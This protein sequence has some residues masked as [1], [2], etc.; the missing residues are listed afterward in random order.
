[1][2]FSGTIQHNDF[3]VVL[4][5]GNKPPFSLVGI[6]KYRELFSVGHGCVPQISSSFAECWFV[7][8]RS[9]IRP[10]FFLVADLIF[11]H[12]KAQGS[13]SP[14]LD[15]RKWRY[16]GWSEFKNSWSFRWIP[17]GQG[18]VSNKFQ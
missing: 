3:R 9:S 18:S 2:S 5:S 11:K 12:K 13:F 15:V 6:Q 8:P 16:F 1:L 14:F 10:R 7:A 17:R 4:G